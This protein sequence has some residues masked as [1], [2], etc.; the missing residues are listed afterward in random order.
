MFVFIPQNSNFLSLDLSNTCENLQYLLCQSVHCLCLRA[1]PLALSVT[2]GLLIFSRPVCLLFA[3]DLV[4]LV[5]L[6]SY[7]RINSPEV[8]KTLPFI[9]QRS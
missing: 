3:C 6:L 8:E 1:L 5:T 9:K 7:S 4:D 2:L